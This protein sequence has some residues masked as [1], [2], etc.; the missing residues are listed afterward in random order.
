MQGGRSKK[1]ISY[2]KQK[3]QQLLPE[4]MTNVALPFRKR[5]II[6]VF[7][8]ILYIGDMIFK[9][10][11]VFTV[12]LFDYIV[13]C[14]FRPI[15][16]SRWYQKVSVITVTRNAALHETGPIKTAQYVHLAT[17]VYGLKYH[18]ADDETDF[19]KYVFTFP[20]AYSEYSTSA[21]RI[22]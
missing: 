20:T 1:N 7:L 9:H 11:C 13:P 19:G 10:A 22:R 8:S 2:S 3:C 18:L 14:A 5:H 21:V 17:F 16:G 4:N 12:K 15:A 6:F